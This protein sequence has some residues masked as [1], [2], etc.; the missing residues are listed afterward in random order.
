MVRPFDLTHDLRSAKGK[1][2]TLRKVEGAAISPTLAKENRRQNRGNPN[3]DLSVGLLCRSSGRSAYWTKVQ[4]TGLRFFDRQ[5]SSLRIFA[6]LVS[7]RLRAVTDE[8]RHPEGM[9]GLYERFLPL[10]ELTMR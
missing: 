10:V 3:G 2:T 5:T 4:Y 6:C 9:R 8:D 7:L 1:L